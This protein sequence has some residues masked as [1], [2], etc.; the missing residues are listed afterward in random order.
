VR[1]VCGVE[2]D[3]A[4]FKGWQIQAGGTRTVQAAVEQAL[5][6]VADQPVQ[7]VCAG[8]TDTGVHATGQVVHFDTDAQRPDRAW[9]MGCNTHLPA[10]VS[11]RWAR[12][13]D[14]DF[15]ARFNAIDR[16]YRYLVVEGASR[17]A[18]W[19]A[20]VAWSTHV[21]DVD[22]MR[23]AAGHLTGEHDFSA[24]RTAA[25][26]ARNPVRCVHALEVERQG[27]FVAIDIRANG[28]LHNMVRIITGT[29]LTIGQGERPP[30]WAGELLA[31]RD[32]TAGGATA[33]AQGL[34]F[35]G[36]RYP[37]RFALPPRDDTASVVP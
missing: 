18:L 30:E 21:L 2:Y 27:P 22:A 11:I 23:A 35:L 15:H 29:L 32:R 9:V 14:G 3:G 12:P 33:P 6:R 8:R 20:R 13:V 10:D 37:E 24:F 19:R 1:I 31:G 26:Q 34:Y 28:F 16:R 25:C 36:P 4:A 5:G 7:T 17:P